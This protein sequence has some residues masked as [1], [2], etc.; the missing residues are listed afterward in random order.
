MCTSQ[1]NR[2]TGKQVRCLLIYLAGFSEAVRSQ[3]IQ[4]ISQAT[5]YRKL[6]SFIDYN[7]VHH[8]SSNYCLFQLVTSAKAKPPPQDADTTKDRQGE[9]HMLKDSPSQLQ[10]MY[11]IP[12]E[13]NME[14]STLL[15]IKIPC[16][17]CQF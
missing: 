4:G 12:N 9:V 13:N 14:P 2:S 8:V 6:G 11:Q 7:F 3:L 5:K 16:L 15:I 17:W 1:V 10:G